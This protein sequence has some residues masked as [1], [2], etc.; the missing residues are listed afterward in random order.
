M[1]NSI[2]EA[3]ESLSAAFK[4]QFRLDLAIESEDGNVLHL[5][6]GQDQGDVKYLGTLRSN[7]LKRNAPKHGFRSIGYELLPEQAGGAYKFVGGA[8]EPKIEEE[9]AV[10]E[11]VELQSVAIVPEEEAIPGLRVDVIQDPE[12][13]EEDHDAELTTNYRERF[14]KEE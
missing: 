9:A 4:R 13:F 1:S 7:W 5:T 6:D 10:I 11:Q 2:E 14:L 3:F 8:P 12:Q